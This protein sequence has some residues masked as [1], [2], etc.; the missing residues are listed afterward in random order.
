MLV[1]RPMTTGARAGGAGCVPPHRRRAKPAGLPVVAVAPG[2][3]AHRRGGPAAEH[4]EGGALPSGE[5][6]D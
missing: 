5:G 4:R 2:D 6:D 3:P 1:D